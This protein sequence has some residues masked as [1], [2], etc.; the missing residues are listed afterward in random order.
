MQ[1]K[2]RVTQRWLSFFVLHSRFKEYIAYNNSNKFQKYNYSDVIL[3]DEKGL[4]STHC[5]IRKP[6]HG[7]GK[8]SLTGEHLPYVNMQTPAP[9]PAD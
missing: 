2:K 1:I 4:Q 5:G 8:R 6:G 3:E 7:D 9:H